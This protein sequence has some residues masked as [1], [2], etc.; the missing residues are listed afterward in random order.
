MKISTLDR[1]FAF[2]MVPFSL[3]M[4]VQS[5]HYGVFGANVT[6][7]GF[8]PF[9][10]GVMILLSS[11]AI[12]AN[13]KARAKFGE[14]AVG[15]GQLK[16]LIGISAATAIFVALADA[17]G[18]IPLTLVYIPAVAYCIEW[19]ARR[20]GHIL[21]WSVAVVATTLFYLLFDQALHIPMPWGIWE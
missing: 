2:T 18:M 14:E 10:S 20:T 5:M 7:S 21:I 17:V 9:I 3:Y 13:G 15:L 1:A 19:P 6:G 16:P 4:I 8:F 11:A 12:L